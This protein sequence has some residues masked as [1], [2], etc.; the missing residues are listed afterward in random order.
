MKNRIVFLDG[1]KDDFYF[2]NHYVLLGNY[3]RDLDRF[4]A[5]DVIFRELLRKAGLTIE[6]EPA[7]AEAKKEYES[8]L[9]QAASTREDI[10]NL[11]EQANNLRK[12]WSAVKDSLQNFLTSG[13]PAD[14]KASLTDIESRLK[15]Q[16]GKLEQLGPK[17]RRAKQKLDFWDKKFES[18]LGD[19]LNNSDTAKVLF[20]ATGTPGAEGQARARHL[21]QTCESTGRARVAVSR[22][23]RV[24]DSFAG[25]GLQPAGALAATAQSGGV[26]G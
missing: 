24:R 3:A 11:E 7:H 12:N 5:M 9:E 6:P 17:N 4:E 21:S 26:E 22:T 10:V 15:H 23:G 8:L 25:G 2:L 19:Y 1:G 18:H 16:E 14:Q 13:D 20:D